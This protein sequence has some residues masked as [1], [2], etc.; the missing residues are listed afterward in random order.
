MGGEGMIWGGGGGG[1][2]DRVEGC[3]YTP[4]N[5]KGIKK[6]QNKPMETTRLT[7]KRTKNCLYI[8]FQLLEKVCIATLSR[9][10]FA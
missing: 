7:Q 9:K 5:K 4:L 1:G 10:D 2:R 3:K 6:T 8:F